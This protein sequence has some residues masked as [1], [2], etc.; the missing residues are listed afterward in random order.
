[1]L[2]T[3]TTRSKML[4]YSMRMVA[5]ILVGTP[6][7]PLLQL[8]LPLEPQRRPRQQQNPKQTRSFRSSSLTET[9]QKL[10][11]SHLPVDQLE[12]LS[13]VGLQLLLLSLLWLLMG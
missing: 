5:Y 11:L 6:T 9:L 13:L 10:R 3:Q 7:S 12:L 1:M 4:P 8:G 2:V